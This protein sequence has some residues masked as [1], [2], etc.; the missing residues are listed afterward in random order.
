MSKSELVRLERDSKALSHSISKLR[1][2]GNTS[3]IYR[4][5]KKQEI[6]KEVIEDF[7]NL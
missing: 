4:L 5:Q 7:E 2:K 6:L 1:K 3:K